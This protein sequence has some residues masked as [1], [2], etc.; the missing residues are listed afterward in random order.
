MTTTTAKPGRKPTDHQPTKEKPKVEKV[1]GGHK[2]TLRGVTVTVPT[3]AFDDFELLDDLRAAQDKQDGSRMPSLLRRLC[4][5]DGYRAVM[6]ALRNETTGR[7]SVED[8]VS[9]VGD[10]FEALAPN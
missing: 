4:G 5:D 3:E 7:V 1:E 8:G 9:F 10:L 6:E 2:V